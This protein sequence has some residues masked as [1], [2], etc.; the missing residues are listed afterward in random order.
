MMKCRIDEKMNRFLTH[1]LEM[2]GFQ[3]MLKN[4]A[5]KSIPATNAL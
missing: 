5:H 3:T 2:E 4:R 1:R